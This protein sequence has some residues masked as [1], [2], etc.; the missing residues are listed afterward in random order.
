MS[1][2]DTDTVFSNETGF[3]SEYESESEIL[4]EMDEILEN[5]KSIHEENEK[6]FSRLKNIQKFFEADTEISIVYENKIQNF[7]E[8]LD[9]LKNKAIRNIEETLQTNF[10]QL[11]LDVIDSQTY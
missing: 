5:T 9:I 10:G 6:S 3:G 11:I 1:D 2:A 4:K 8:V 7:C